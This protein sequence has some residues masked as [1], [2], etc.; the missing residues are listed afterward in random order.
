MAV[1]F[2]KDLGRDRTRTTKTQ[3][4]DLSWV[5]DM[6][7]LIAAWVFWLLMSICVWHLPSGRYRKVVHASLTHAVGADDVD[8]RRLFNKDCL[9][10][11]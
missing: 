4:T 10:C 9:L 2:S 6:D 11:V 1:L 5:T 8:V 3:A 7:T